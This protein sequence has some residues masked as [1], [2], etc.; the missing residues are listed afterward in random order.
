MIINSEDL[1][2]REYY[3]GGQDFGLNIAGVKIGYHQDKIYVVKDHGGHNITT[4]TF[5]D[6]LILKGWYEDDFPV[7]CDPAR[8][9]RIQEI[10]GG[11]KAKNAVD[12]GLDYIN[13]LIERERF[14]ISSECSGVLSEIWDYS[15]DEDDKIIKINDHYMDAVRYAIF[16]PVQQ[17]VIIG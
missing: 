3:T 16:S 2:E 17:G 6:Q 9:E 4:K 14:F 7:Y 8:G 15:R 5:N 12:S 10:T 13:S 1:P 11:I